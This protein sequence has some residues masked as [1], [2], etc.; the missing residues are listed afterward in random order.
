[1]CETTERATGARR[2]ARARAAARTED[3]SEDEE[4]DGDQARHSVK[5]SFM[6]KVFSP[7][8]GYGQDF[9]LLQFMYDLTLWSRIGGGKNAY[10]SALQ[11]DGPL[12]VQLPAP[13]L[14]P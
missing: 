2:L 14:R 9:E 13:H 8:V 11:D 4:E 3:L 5:R 7:I 10:A 12:G 1:M 6:R